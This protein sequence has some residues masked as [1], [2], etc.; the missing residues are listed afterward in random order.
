MVFGTDAGTG[1]V[2]DDGGSWSRMTGTGT[3][4]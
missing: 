2:N 3:T 1:E 4:D